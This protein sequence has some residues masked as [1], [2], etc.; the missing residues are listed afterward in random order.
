MNEQNLLDLIYELQEPEDFDS[1]LDTLGENHTPFY[2]TTVGLAFIKHRVKKNVV[3]IYR[4]TEI[5]EPINILLKRVRRED[6]H[7]LRE[8]AE[9][10]RYG[11]GIE[12]HLGRAAYCYYLLALLENNEPT[13]IVKIV[14]LFETI[15]DVLFD[16]NEKEFGIVYYQMAIDFLRDEFPLNT[17]RIDLLA[18]RMRQSFHIVS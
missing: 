15:G 11:N 4:D 7:A 8:L 16:F 1:F 9:R 2:S 13:G 18:K 10:L 3:W 14:D 17:N 5:S 6:R 12:K